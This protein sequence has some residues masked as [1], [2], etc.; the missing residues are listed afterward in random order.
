MLLWLLVLLAAVQT[1]GKDPNP[2][3]PYMQFIWPPEGHNFIV[4]EEIRYSVVN[5]YALSKS[6]AHAAAMSVEI[7]QKF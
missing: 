4:G 6:A 5:V 3:Q 2:D 7:R 1:Q